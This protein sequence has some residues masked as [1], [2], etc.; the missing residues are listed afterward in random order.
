MPLILRPATEKDAFRLGCIGRDAFRHH[1]SRDL[2]PPHLRS[3]S[4]SGDPDFDEAEWRGMRTVRRMKEGKPAYVVVDVSEG[5]IPDEEG[6]VVGFCQWELPSEGQEKKQNFEDDANAD[7]LPPILDSQA[8]H[9]M[10]EVI[11]RES[12]KILGSEGY[13]KMWFDPQHQ[14]RGVGRMLIQHGLELAAKDGRDAFLIGTPEGRCLYQ[15]LGFEVI[16]EP[17][18]LGSTLHYPMLW[19][20][21]KV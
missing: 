8:Y 15:K 13:S 16:G 4:E 19:K 3:K 2:F 6:L 11:D 9:A 20:A 17:F 18:Y 14:R 5:G 12:H 21:P 10:G 1:V 7:R